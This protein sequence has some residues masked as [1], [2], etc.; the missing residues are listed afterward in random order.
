MSVLVSIHD[1]TPA[2][3][4]EA[5]HLWELC[6]AHGV[7][8]A[9][10]VVPNWHGQWPLERYP[11]FVSWLRDRAAEGAEIVLHGE[12]HDE[13]GLS[14]S[15][16]D[17]LRAWGHT[18]REG[19]FLTL[20]AAAARARIDRGVALLR[21]LG[22]PPIGFVPPGW[23]A[24]EEGHAAVA[25]AGLGFSEDDRA[26]R[27]YPAGGRLAS[28]AVRW[29]ARSSARAWGSVAV[30]RGR[31]ITQ[32]ASA[33]PRLAFH[34]QDLRHP[35]VARDLPR[36]LERWLGRHKP[37]PYEGLRRRVLASAAGGR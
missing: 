14:R 33:Y 19:E 7:V 17:R 8:P 37:I 16:R 1:V 24:R 34:P 36:A 21:S 25:D 6:A 35:A 30:A 15:R 20:E 31:W 3:A 4:P 29:S 23:L 12:R 9:L 5:F 22:L 28:P 11:G 26:I 18:V 10:F 32:R 2:L 13:S 27:F